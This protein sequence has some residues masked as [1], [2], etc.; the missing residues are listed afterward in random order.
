MEAT[1]YFAI[2]EAIDDA[3]AE[4]D[5]RVGAIAPASESV[6]TRIATAREHIVAGRF[7]DAVQLIGRLPP[8]VRAL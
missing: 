2:A 8:R 7:D 6:E 3:C 1:A 5:R 4:V